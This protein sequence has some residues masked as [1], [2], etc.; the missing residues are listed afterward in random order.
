[1]IPRFLRGRFR[2]H[3]SVFLYPH[4]TNQLLREILD[5]TKASGRAASRRFWITVFISLLVVLL[6]TFETPVWKIILDLFRQI[7]RT[8]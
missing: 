4:T 3:K 7:L 6:A 8:N 1:M 5:E 2:Q